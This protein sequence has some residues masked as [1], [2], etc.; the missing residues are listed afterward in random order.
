VAQRVGEFRQKAIAAAEVRNR[1]LHRGWEAAPPR[2][3]TLTKNWLSKAGKPSSYS[4]TAKDLERVADSFHALVK[5]GEAVTWE[6]FS[7]L[8]HPSR[9]NKAKL[10][11]VA[12]AAAGELSEELQQE[13][14]SST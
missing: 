3:R 14:D 8:R 7:A 13:S 6:V 2:T 11:A 4:Y 10:W 9:G 5:R 1:L 12:L